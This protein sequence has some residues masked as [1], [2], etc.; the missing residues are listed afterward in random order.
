M[1]N[2]STKSQ[3]GFISFF[4]QL[5]LPGMRIVVLATGKR[6]PAGEAGITITLLLG[7]KYFIANKNHK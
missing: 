6:L 4:N 7:G 1:Y 5:M 3:E 2:F